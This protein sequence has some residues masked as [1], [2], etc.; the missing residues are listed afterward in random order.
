M[1]QKLPAGITNA[2]NFFDGMDGLAACMAMVMAFFMGIVTYETNSR[3]WL[4]VAVIGSCL[5]CFFYNFRLGR[6]LA[7]I[8]IAIVEHY[9]WCENEP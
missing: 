3:A 1:V 9:A 7:L 6:G 5:G 4:A 8:M 2:F